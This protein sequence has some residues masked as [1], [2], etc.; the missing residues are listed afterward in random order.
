MR[1]NLLS[2]P[3][4]GLKC[5]YTVV[6]ILCAALKDLIFIS[7]GTKDWFGKGQLVTQKE[8]YVTAY[9]WLLQDFYIM[10]YMFGVSCHLVNIPRQR[11]AVIITVAVLSQLL[12]HT[13]EG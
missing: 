13:V 3:S 8:M 6:M 4:G 12:Q 2:L 10:A 5:M 7:V 1:I 11:F 9:D